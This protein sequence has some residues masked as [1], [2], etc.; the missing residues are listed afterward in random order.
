LLVQSRSVILIVRRRG[1]SRSRPVLGR[2]LKSE[3]RYEDALIFNVFF[4]GSL[5]SFV[6]GFVRSATWRF[7]MKIVKSLVL[8][9]AAGLLALGGGAQAADLPVKAKPVEYVRICSLY[10]AGF[11]YIPGT[12]TC[13][14]I[15]GYMRIDTTFNG[16]IYDGPAWNGDLGQGN[17]FADY[18]NSRSRMALTVDTRTATE[19]GV[20]RTFLQ[21][22]FQFNN[23]GTTNSA[24]LGAAPAAPGGLSNALLSGVGGGYVAVEFAFIQF[25]G[26]TF[27]KSA[28]AYATPWHGY[29]GNNS[30]FLL[31][32]HDTVTGVNN[33]QYSWQFGNGVSAT[34][35]LDDPTVFNRTPLANLILGIGAAGQT[36]ASN[37]GGFIVPD[38]VGNVRV[39]QAWGLFQFSGALHAVNASYNNVTTPNAPTGLTAIGDIGTPLNSSVLSGHPGSKVGGSVMAAFQIKNIPT[40]P[41]DDIKFDASWAKGDTKNVISTSATSPTFLMLGGVPGQFGPDRSLAF[42]PTSDGLYLPRNLLGL[43][44]AGS[45][46]RAASIIGAS[47][48]DGSIHLTEAYGL[49]GAF[50]HNWDPYWS[51]SLFGSYS[52]VRFDNQAKLEYC[53]IAALSIPGQ[54]VSYTCN[55][56]YDVTQLGFITRWTPVTNLTFSAESIWTHLDTGFKGFTGVFSPANGQPSQVWTFKSQDSLTLNVRV[57]RNF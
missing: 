3:L 15:G 53:A 40:G 25:A 26:F 48:F 41:G 22:D 9:S 46:T 11:W 20:V 44:A 38:L 17:R 37:Y 39:D 28:S 45:L 5:H 47:F 34:I 31:G 14:K 33:I 50:N 35:G 16:N 49:R 8:G 27:G 42:G 19:Y 4:A 56:N 7:N 55:P 1:A 2:S 30:S 54:G 12:D 43:G 32:G 23:F 36:V 29:P 51:S 52:W 24:V 10:G 18:I 21:G 57:Q 6:R 13:I